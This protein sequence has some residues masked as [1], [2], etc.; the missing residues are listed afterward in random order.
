MGLTGQGLYLLR[1]QIDILKRLLPFPPTIII[2]MYF[3]TNTIIYKGLPLW[4][5]DR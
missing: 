2:G 3:C 4:L 5:N 1:Q